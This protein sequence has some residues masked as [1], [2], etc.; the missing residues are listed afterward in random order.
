MLKTKVEKELGLPYGP[1]ETALGDAVV[2]GGMYA[3]AAVIPLW[4]YLVWSV[5]TALV[6]SLVATGLAL[7]GLGLVKGRVAGMALARSG[8][9]VLLIGGGSAA[10]GYLIGVL[11]PELF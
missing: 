4:P 3:L 1:T 2:V 5:G 10:I 8:L 11:V 7:F 6:V 9:Q